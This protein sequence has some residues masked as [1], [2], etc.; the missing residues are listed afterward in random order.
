MKSPRLKSLV[1]LL[2]AAVSLAVF[3]GMLSG[4][5][6]V[7]S[8]AATSSAQNTLVTELTDADDFAALVTNSDIP[9]LIEFYATWC[10]PCHMVAPDLEALAKAQNGKVKVLRVDIDRS[11][12]LAT[13]FRVNAVPTAIL[14][15]PKGGGQKQVL[16][17]GDVR[18]LIR[19]LNH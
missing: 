6:R 8:L 18:N 15:Q 1:W 12:K 3:S 5:G 17:V 16:G 2:L 10:G 14:F 11:P 9:V 7:Q 19:S 13:R 4:A